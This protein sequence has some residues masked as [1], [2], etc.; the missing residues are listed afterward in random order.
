MP[1]EKGTGILISRKR[2]K[3]GKG[4]DHDRGRDK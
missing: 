2:S 4:S 1:T 3:I